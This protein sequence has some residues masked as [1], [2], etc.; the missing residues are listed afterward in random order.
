MFKPVYAISAQSPKEVDILIY[1]VIGESFWGDG[2]PGK[3][4]VTDFNALEQK[5]D[6]INIRINSPGGSVWDGLPMFNAIKSSKK[7]THT[8]V[9]G[10][11][12][13][14]GAMIALA[15]K[16][17]HAAKGSLF[18]LHNVLGFAIGNAKDL[19]NTADEMDIYDEVLGQLIADKTGKTLEQVKKDWMNHEDHLM[20]ATTAF[21]NK[22]VDVVE[23]YDAKDMPDNVKD[24]SIEDVMNFYNPKKQNDQVENIEQIADQVSKIL[25]NNNMSLFGTKFKKLNALSG[26]KAADI[27]DA[28]I[29]AVNQELA[30]EGIE[31]VVVITSAHAQEADGYADAADNA[32]TAINTSLGLTG[33][34]AHKTLTAAVTGLVAAHKAEHDR[35]EEYGEQPGAEPTKPKAAQ[36]EGEA[37]AEGGTQLPEKKNK[38]FNTAHD[39]ALAKK[40]E[41]A[42]NN[43]FNPS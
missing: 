25:T 2:N 32:L 10:I 18:L 36:A 37:Q 40:I 38:M 39:Q 27:S 41:A 23:S 3:K 43:P 9:D 1:G 35:A 42:K 11:A 16:T 28:E 26:K 22:L 34:K 19:R 8:Y 20:S 4:F 31:N 14:M 30:A 17:V 15:G 29:V 12:Y 21:E 33:D 24:M 13:S 6:R 5:Y 7:D